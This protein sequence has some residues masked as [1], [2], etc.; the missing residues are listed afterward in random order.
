M[1]G[2]LTPD[3]DPDP[4]PPGQPF[5]L[6]DNLGP[7]AA[8]LAL[9]LEVAG[10]SAHKVPATVPATEGSDPPHASHAAAP[11]HACTLRPAQR[12]LPSAPHPL[13]LHVPCR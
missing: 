12:Q 5:V 1:Y 2:F 10:V 9:A 6:Y 4:T 7:P 11:M 8:V 3:K 13:S